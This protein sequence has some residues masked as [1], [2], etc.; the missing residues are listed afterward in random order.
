MRYVSKAQEH[1]LVCL[2]AFAPE[3]MWS[4]ARR[5]ERGVMSRGYELRLLLQPPGNALHQGTR[6]QQLSL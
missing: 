1:D 2:P 6:C 3:L 4:S 5:T